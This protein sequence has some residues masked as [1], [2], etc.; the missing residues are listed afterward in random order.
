MRVCQFRHFGVGCFILQVLTR[1]TQISAARGVQ[2]RTRMS[3]AAPAQFTVSV[4]TVDFETAPEI[5]F[6]VTMYVVAGAAVVDATVF[7]VV[8]SFMLPPPHAICVINNVSSAI[9]MPSF[10]RRRIVA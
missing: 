4:T 2:L 6:T 7:G 8:L 3:H 5:A 9:P 10:L 1:I